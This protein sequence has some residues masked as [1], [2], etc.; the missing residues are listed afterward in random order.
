V[1]P[2]IFDDYGQVVLLDSLCQAYGKRPSE[3]IG[4]SELDE[5]FAYDFDLTVM[6]KAERIRKGTLVHPKVVQERQ[7]AGISKVK[8]IVAKVKHLT[9]KRNA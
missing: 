9:R 6:S 7:A 8:A 5:L 4:I 1:Y 2:L 3:V